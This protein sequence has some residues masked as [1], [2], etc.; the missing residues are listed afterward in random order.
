MSHAAPRLLR[1][2]LYVPA[3]NPRALAKAATL[4]ADAL[5]LDLEDSVAPEAKAEAR[6]Q[7]RETLEKL[8]RGGVPLRTV[9]INGLESPHWQKDVAMVLAGRPDAL[10]VP[11]VDEPVD[12]DPLLDLLAQLEEEEGLAHLPLW[13]MIESPRAVLHAHGIA[14]AHRVEC[15]LL[16]S[17]DLAKGLRLRQGADRE[18][19]G[20]ALQ[21]VVLAARAAECGV[22]DGVYGDLKD[23]EGFAEECRW[24]ARL[25]FDGKSLIHPAQVGPANAAFLPGDDEVA[26]ARAVLAA[27]GAAR[28]R[29]EEICVVEGRLVER[30]HAQEAQRLLDLWGEANPPP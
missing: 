21:Q 20:H 8:P 3:S 6:R 28:E 5:I 7:A 9:R 27:W 1:S 16:G 18:G 11:K 2:V 30:L 14:T 22:L 10:V 29:G 15:L 19:L 26:R 23:P 24:A 4:G 12:L 25:G 13:P 17:N